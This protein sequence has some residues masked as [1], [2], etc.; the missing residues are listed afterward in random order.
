VSRAR[1]YALSLRRIRQAPGGLAHWLVD[2]VSIAA[3]YTSGD[4]RSSLAEATAQS[5]AVTADYA[6]QPRS[7]S[8]PAAPR[9]LVALVRKLPPFIGKSGFAD[10]L[11]RA[12]LRL[13]PTGIRLRSALAGGDA[14]RTSFRIPVADS[15]DLH[16]VPARSRTR[17]WRN[18]ASLDLLPLAGLQLRGDLASQ[19]DL[20]DYGDST[21]IARVAQLAR[22]SLLGLDVGFESQ[23]TVGT[24]YGLTPRLMP[25]LQPRFTLSTGFSLTRDPNGRTPIRTGGDSGAFRLPTAFSNSQRLDVGTQVDLGRLGRGLFGD[26]SA[27]VRGLSKVTSLDLGFSR[28][29]SSSYSALAT[30][31]GLGY[32]L[33]LTGLAAFRSQSGVPAT[34]AIDNSTRHASGTVALPL[35]FRVTALYERTRGTSWLLRL[36]GQAQTQTRS[37][38]WPSGTVSW[39]FSPPRSS[40]GRILSGLTAQLAVRRRETANEQPS[41]GTETG[42]GTALTQTSERS[43]APGITASWAHGILTTFDGT[44][45]RTEQVTAGNLFRT[46]RTQRNA[47]IAFAWRPPTALIRLKSDIRTT[48]R[49]SYAMNTTCLQSAGR[50]TCTPYVDSRQTNAQL[51]LDTSFPPSLSAGFQMAY[52]LD[53]ERQINHKVAQV[54]LTAFVQLNTSVGQIR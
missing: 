5:F 53:D 43:L 26:S 17:V 27:I 31:P 32:Q 2:P 36:S 40:V 37:R 23:R 18:T 11:D 41:L 7:A 12:R 19:R 6:I 42:V 15:S 54:V 38:E 3:S 51:T 35:G 25:W 39:T 4:D 28:D 30:A 47:S 20:R 45:L 34:S 10:G 8:I 1:S 50:Q 16:L 13:S 21:S 49:Y 9:F 44:R 33:A 29:R 48:A 14:S 22:K 46:T 52:V 24:F